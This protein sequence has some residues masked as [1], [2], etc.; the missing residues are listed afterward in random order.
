[1]ALYGTLTERHRSPPSEMGV[2][3]EQFFSNVFAAINPNPGT[4]RKLHKGVTRA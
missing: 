1:M 4:L 3:M 2:L